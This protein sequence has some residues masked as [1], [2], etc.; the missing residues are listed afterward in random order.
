MTEGGQQEYDLAGQY[1][2]WAEAV[3]ATHPRTAAA[4]RD[5]YGLLG[6]VGADAVVLL[7]RHVTADGWRA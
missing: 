6:L 5:R 3:Q 2:A 4:L 7:D 1:A